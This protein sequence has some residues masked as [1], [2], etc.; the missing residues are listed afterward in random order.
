M[1]ERETEKGGLLGKV[2]GLTQWRGEKRRVM[3]KV[4]KEKTGNCSQEGRIISLAKQKRSVYPKKAKD[5]L[6]A[7]GED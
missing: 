1:E 5:T 4:A 6:Q 7:K 2:H 3:W